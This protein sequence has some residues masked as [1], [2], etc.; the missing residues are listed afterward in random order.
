MSTHYVLVTTMDPGYN[1]NDINTTVSSYRAL[2]TGHHAHLFI[3]I[4][5][6]TPATSYEK[7]AL[8]INLWVFIMQENQLH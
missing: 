4:N 2:W 1:E 8:I 7:P 3:Y 6:L 5:L